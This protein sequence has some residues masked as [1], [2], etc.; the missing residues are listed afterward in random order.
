VTGWK[1]RL[2]QEQAHGSADSPTDAAADLAREW[3]ITQFDAL[4]D[5]IQALYSAICRLHDDEKKAGK[6]ISL[7]GQNPSSSDREIRY[8]NQ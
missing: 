8:A 1:E 7:V 2:H 4:I 3:L 5:A 6:E